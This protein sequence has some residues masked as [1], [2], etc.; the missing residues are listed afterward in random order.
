MKADDS[1]L[2]MLTTH[3]LN[4]TSLIDDAQVF[5]MVRYKEDVAS[6]RRFWFA[7]GNLRKDFLLNGLSINETGDNE[8]IEGDAMRVEVWRVFG[9][10][11]AWGYH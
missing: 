4:V 2:Q 8:I 7:R 5:F 11:Y 1:L 10:P 6:Q 3:V 9:N